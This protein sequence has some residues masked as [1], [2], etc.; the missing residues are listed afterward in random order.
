MRKSTE[1]PVWLDK[2]ETKEK[3]RGKQVLMYCTGGVR[4]E[5]ASALLRT[6]MET[7]EDTKA[8]GIKGVYQLQGGIDKY[9]RDYPEG[10]CWKGK[11]YTFD[12]RFAHA[13]PVIEGME[14]A[15]KMK[16]KDAEV[17]SADEKLEIMGKCEACQKPW[18]KYR[19]K[20]RCPTCGVPSLI[21]KEC[22]DLDKSKTKKL[23]KNVR[24]DLCTKEGVTSKRQLKDKL[25]REMESYE[26]K[27]REVY[28][29]QISPKKNKRV[30]Q[31]GGLPKKPTAA[32]NPEGITKLFIKNLCARQVDQPE[33]CELIPGITHIEWITD[34]KTGNWY[35][36]VFVEVATPEDA[37]IA[38]GSVNKKKCFG[39][40]V[41]VSYSPPDPKSIWPPSK[42]KI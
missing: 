5:R 11:N 3:L 2:P 22:Y 27:L 38:V 24:C 13:P 19:G 25:E 21:C 1:F 15:M 10:G 37:A 41:N 30:S 42:F 17:D 8:L 28:G 16:E 7:E 9:F 6:K 39:R 31:T 36:S 35:G 29:F 20:R 34:R 23:D 18:D 32:P 26:I 33:L 12:K 40:I 4:C 14:R